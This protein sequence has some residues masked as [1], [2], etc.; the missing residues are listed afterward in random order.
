M[1]NS[2]KSSKYAIAYANMQYAK[3]RALLITKV[4]KGCFNSHSFICQNERKKKVVLHFLFHIF[5]KDKEK[6]I[7]KCLIVLLCHKLSFFIQIIKVKF[8]SWL[9]SNH[10]PP[11]YE[12][13]VLE[14]SH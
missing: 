8:C 9:D 13:G 12:S 5:C 3:I 2:K 6:K 11:D 7:K 1:Q 14:L 10:R 4:T